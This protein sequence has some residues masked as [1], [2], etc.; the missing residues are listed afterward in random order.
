MDTIGQIKKVM[1]EMER[2]IFHFESG[3]TY[4]VCVRDISNIA[5]AVEGFLIVLHSGRS[6]YVRL[7]AVE[8]IEFIPKTKQEE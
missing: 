5:A 6:I 4:A 3:K 1:S 7:S 8:I 2:M